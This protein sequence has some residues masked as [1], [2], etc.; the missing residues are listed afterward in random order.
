MRTTSLFSLFIAVALGRPAMCPAQIESPFEKPLAEINLQLDSS[1]LKN[2]YLVVRSPSGILPDARAGFENKITHALVA[3][4]GA[5]VVDNGLTDFHDDDATIREFTKRREALLNS[6]PGTKMNFFGL[7]EINGF[8]YTWVS[9]DVPDKRVNTRTGR[10]HATLFTTV[11]DGWSYVVFGLGDYQADAASAAEDAVNALRPLRP[12][13]SQHPGTFDDYHGKV[14]GFETHL[15]DIGW[16]DWPNSQTAFPGSFVA[17]RKGESAFI[18]V[19]VLPMPER[20]LSIEEHLAA[21][22]RISTRFANPENVFKFEATT[23]KGFDKALKFAAKVEEAQGKTLLGGW[24]GQ[25]GG[26]MM[27]TFA[28]CSTERVK[29][30]GSLIESALQGVEPLIIDGM[31]APSAFRLPPSATSSARCKAQSCARSP[32]C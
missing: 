6:Q 2:S 1:T 27:F 31:P 7:R 17:A 10:L 9:Y 32:A 5:D 15:R 18:V 30:A 12:R 22:M 23:M 11:R 14:H 16:K 19:L 4:S 21:T 13:G 20:G 29:D 25:G 24:F 8:T 26:R 28:W 3:I